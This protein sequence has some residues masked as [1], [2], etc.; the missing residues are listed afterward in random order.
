M[1][2]NFVSLLFL[3][4]AA[5][6]AAESISGS[7]FPKDLLRREAFSAHKSTTA[8]IYGNASY[9]F[10]KVPAHP[11]GGKIDIEFFPPGYS[12]PIEFYAAEADAKG[13]FLGRR[14]YSSPF[15]R[16]NVEPR[17][18][19]QGS[20]SKP[21][22]IM[23]WEHKGVRSPVI[24]NRE[25]EPVWTGPG[26]IGNNPSPRGYVPIKTEPDQVLVL[27]GAAKMSYLLANTKTG[28]GAT[29]TV[30]GSGMFHH[31]S[32]YI[33]QTKELV[34]L[35]YQCRELPW[36]R[37]NSP[38]FSGL[39]NWLNLLKL[40][41]RTYA[42]STVL[43]VNLSSGEAREVWSTAQSFVYP[44]E[45]NLSLL[46][47]MDRYADIKTISAYHSLLDNPAF[48]RAEHGVD[49]DVDWSHE[50]SVRF[51]PGEGY[52]VSIRNFNKVVMIG[53]DG[54]LK[55]TLGGSERDTFQIR[56]PEERFSMQHD[57]WLIGPGQV[58]LFDNHLPFRG[59]PD[60]RYSRS[61]RVSQYRFANGQ[62]IREWTH[63][64]PG[65]RADLRGTVQPLT[66]GNVFVFDGFTKNSLRFFEIRRDS[67]S[68]IVAQMTMALNGEEPPFEARPMDSI[69]GEIFLPDPNQ[70][71]TRLN[72][73]AIEHEVRSGY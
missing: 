72:I 9:G 16:A 44:E 47:D 40:P 18:E 26:W 43:R 66:N 10:F 15:A 2:L 42:G 32:D 27:G 14:S 70:G 23:S 39:T 63:V 49:C 21:F 5:H 54:S 71:K 1:L 69:A 53:E 73:E 64:I 35:G 13:K 8:I 60:N 67:E 24:F 41:R 51:Y 25:G 50:N 4:P 22:F 19:K 3:S 7:N 11:K 61:S 34:A 29:H 6:S 62:A 59:W 38:V 52:L 12:R 55:W 57:A 46:R 37:E 33:P 58:L 45:P 30:Q 28:A 31:V 36:W 48:T 56:R 68:A 65:P 20:F 17:V